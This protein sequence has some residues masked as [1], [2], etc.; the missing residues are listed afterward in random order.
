MVNNQTLADR[1]TDVK[2]KFHEQWYW[3]FGNRVDE[4]DLEQFCIEYG[5]T[6]TELADVMTQTGS[7]EI[8][9]SDI[10]LFGTMQTVHKML[11]PTDPYIGEKLDALI[12]EGLVAHLANAV[13]PAGAVTQVIRSSWE[14]NAWEALQDTYAVTHVLS[15]LD[16]LGESGRIY[17]DNIMGRLQ[18]A[19]ADQPGLVEYFSPSGVEMLLDT[20]ISISLHRE[21]LPQDPDSLLEKYAKHRNASSWYAALANVAG[22]GRFRTLNSFLSTRAG[23][24]ALE[25]IGVPPGHRTLETSPVEQL[26]GPDVPER[27][28][29]VEYDP[30]GFQAWLN[31]NLYEA[32]SAGAD[33]TYFANILDH[34][35]A[36][37]HLFEFVTDRIQTLTGV[38]EVLHALQAED[39]EAEIPEYLVPLHDA[40]H[41]P[42]YDSNQ[43]LRQQS[44]RELR[45]NL[46][47][48]MQHEDYQAF[49][50]AVSPQAANVERYLRGEFR[51]T[52][53]LPKLKG[54]SDMIAQYN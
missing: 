39:V 8:D 45:T 10:A 28:D 37:D 1:I 53:Y 19:F 31:H 32:L 16:H 20:V 3:R 30:H 27:Y 50:A 7:P 17:R 51:D 33:E 26:N 46:P 2:K 54:L 36:R 42:T 40:M 43:A 25:A 15:S 12:N 6:A 11:D 34:E 48:V 47:H 35:R 41:D 13:A 4:A 44:I 49:A 23:R 14:Q 29:V 18:A 22:S 52:K 21:G 38:T 24:K 5:N 9:G